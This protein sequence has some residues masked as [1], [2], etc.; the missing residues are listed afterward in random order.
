[1]PLAVRWKNTPR[2]S[3]SIAYDTFTLTV[4]FAFA[5]SVCF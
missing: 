4:F 5:V 1:L 2:I 3:G